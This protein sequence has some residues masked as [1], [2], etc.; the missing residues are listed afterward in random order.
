[1]VGVFGRT[2][3]NFLIVL[4]ITGIFMNS[5]MI[6]GQ[7][8][9]GQMIVGHVTFGHMIFGQMFFGQMIFGQ[10]FFGQMIFGQ[11]IFGQLLENLKT[12]QHSFYKKKTTRWVSLKIKT[13][14]KVVLCGINVVEKCFFARRNGAPIFQHG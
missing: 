8:I 10:M 1:M 13:F 2:R 3:N 12:S 4:V 5:Q 6:F 7:M 14:Q 11:M 9:F